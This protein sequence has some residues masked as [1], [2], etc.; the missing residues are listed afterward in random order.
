[1]FAPSHTLLL[2]TGRVL[3]R[4]DLSGTR[5]LR[6]QNAWAQQ[7]TEP[8]PPAVAAVTALN[9]GPRRAGRVWVLSSDFWTGV[10]SLA[11]DVAPLLSHDELA[12]ALALEAEIDSGISAFA[13]R[14]GRLALSEQSAGGNTR[15]CVTHIGTAELQELSHALKRLGAHV[16]GAAHPAAAAIVS[17][18]AEDTLDAE[19]LLTGWEERLWASRGDD[20]GSLRATVIRWAECWTDCLAQTPPMSLVVRAEAKPLSHAQ[21]I[22]CSAAMALVAAGACGL[23][24]W[25]TQTRILTAERAITSLEQRQSAQETLQRSLQALEARVAKLRKEALQAEAERRVLEND[26]HR[27]DLAHTQHNHR[28]SALLD[29]IS[30]SIDEQCW[31]QQLESKPVRATIHG[32]AI[33]NTAAHR[34]ASALELGLAGSGW[35]VLPAD[36]RPT[37]H[38]LVAFKIVLEASLDSHQAEKSGVAQLSNVDADDRPIDCDLSH[39]LHIRQARASGYQRNQPASGDYRQLANRG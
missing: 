27:A 33:D 19:D 4:V 15:W 8:V 1:M 35:T 18:A 24:N 32:L 25:H 10:L 6:V 23:W 3:A 37:E 22:A 5:R 29:A 14:V 28:W 12:Q 38:H 34:F 36:T 9:L 20:A 2:I 11:A 21:R 26:L 16:V 31:I 39:Q 17:A 30:S 13:S 7:C